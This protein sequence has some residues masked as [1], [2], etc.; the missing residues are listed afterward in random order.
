[1]DSK[2]IYIIEV[3]QNREFILVR[4]ACYFRSEHEPKMKKKKK[5][6]RNNEPICTFTFKTI[7]EKSGKRNIIRV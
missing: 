3:L 6:H 1:M 4:N 7:G 2:K 5:K